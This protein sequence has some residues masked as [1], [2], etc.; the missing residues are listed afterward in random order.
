MHID[1]V[2]VNRDI[3]N[4]GPINM[5][6]SMS[7]ENGLL[8]GATCGEL[9]ERDIGR[10]V[11]LCGWV[12]KSRNLGGLYFLDLRDKYGLTQLSFGPSFGGDLHILKEC[13]L[14]SVLKVEGVVAARPEEA[15]NKNMETGE[16]EIHVASVELLSRCDVDRLPFLPHGAIEST[17]ELRLKYRY[18]DLRTSTL[19]KTLKARSNLMASVRD[20]LRGEHFIEVETPILYKS[21]PEGARDYIVPSRVHQGQV[22][23]LPQSPQT[24]KQLLMFGGVDRYFQI[25]RCFRDEDLRYDRQPE[26]SQ[27]DLEASFVTP[28]YIKKLVEKMLAKIFDLPENFE[29]PHMSYGDAMRDYGT[30]RP[31]IRFGLKHMDVTNLFK[32]SSFTPLSS[33]SLIKALFVPVSMGTFSRKEIESF[34]KGIF[35]FK[36]SEGKCSGGIGKFVTDSILNGF[37]EENS[38]G[39]WFLVAGEDSTA[40]H[41]K[42]DVLRRTLGNKLDLLGKEKKFLWITDFPLFNWEEEQKRFASCHHPFTMPTH[43]SLDD[44]MANKNIAGLTAQAY[45]VVCNGQELGGGSIRIHRKDIQEKVFEV[46]GMGKEEQ[47]S[48]FGFFLEALGYGGI[49]P[50]GGIAFGLDRIVMMKAEVHSIRD[51]IAFPKTNSARDLMSGAPSVP[52]EQ[53]LSELGMH[54][55]R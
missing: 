27:I 7:E 9:R 12:N 37:G 46:L 21:T 29:L 19:Q 38:D 8:R 23:A 14:E 13:T 16:I 32:E 20:F 28:A 34:G 24:L 6:V 48:Q 49:P 18:L 35:F 3:R 43:E 11:I 40:I 53:Q 47:E 31:D 54:F 2:R 22:Y 36:V 4:Y 17:E 55:N 50:H 26:F 10:R 52:D 51:V 44:L 30:D 42:A 1:E 39:I 15:I 45:D 25:C 5:G 33:A 41:A